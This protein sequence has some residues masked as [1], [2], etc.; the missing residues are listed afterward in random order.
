MLIAGDFNM[1]MDEGSN[2]FWAILK[3]ADLTQHVEERTHT[4]GHT[5]DLLTSRSADTFLENI[6]VDVPHTSDHSAV[7]CTLR[8]ETPPNVRLKMTSRSYK[9][10]ALLRFVRI[11]DRCGCRSLCRMIW[12]MQSTLQHV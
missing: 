4:A 2:H 9:H 1:H 8:L 3:A 12:T 6:R 7:H 5:V 11:Y 10:V